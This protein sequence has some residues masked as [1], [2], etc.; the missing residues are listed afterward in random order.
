M[1]L[2]SFSSGF[3]GDVILCLEDRTD[4]DWRGPFVVTREIADPDTEDEEYSFETFYEAR[5]KFQE[6]VLLDIT[7]TP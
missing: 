4:L 1:S 2:F 6:I 7:E 5:A 3:S